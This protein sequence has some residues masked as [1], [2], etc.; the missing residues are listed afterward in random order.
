MKKKRPA[1]ILGINPEK[2]QKCRPQECEKCGWETSE[3]AERDERIRKEGL[4]RGEYGLMGMR[5][6]KGVKKHE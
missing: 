1:C 4:K 3:A 2:S 5:V 6:Y